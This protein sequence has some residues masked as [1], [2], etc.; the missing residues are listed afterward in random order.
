[1]KDIVVKLKEYPQHI[2]RYALVFPPSDREIMDKICQTIPFN[3]RYINHIV[4]SGFVE[5]PNLEKYTPLCDQG[6]KI[7]RGTLTYYIRIYIE[8]K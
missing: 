2:Q 3:C 1:M 4:E 8:E 7:P 5:D 6:L